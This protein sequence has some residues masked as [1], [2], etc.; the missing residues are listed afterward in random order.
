MTRRTL[1]LP[2]L[3]ALLAAACT[4][5]EI[6]HATPGTITVV[7]TTTQMQ[8]LVRNVGG[9][10]V[11]MVGILRPN[12][13]PHDYEPT[14]STA[15]SLAGAGLVVESGVGVDAW[16][17]DLVSAANPDTPVFVAADGLPVRTGSAG[18]PQ[19]DPHWWHDPTLFE[20]AATALGARLARLDPS[21]ARAYRANAARY[22]AAITAMDR[23]NMRL[24]ATVPRSQRKLVTNH[25]AFG[26]FAAHYGITVVGSV[27]PSL[28]TAAQPSARDVAD[29]VGRIRAQHVRA[30]FTESSLN[31]ALERQIAAEAGVRVEAD[32]YGDTLGPAGS[33]GATYLGMERWN[34]RAI[35]AGLLGRPAPQTSA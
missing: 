27:L 10:H 9:R 4:T 2:P 26:Y 30:I 29:L 5:T 21:H 20:R 22:V 15:I 12:V 13:D 3:L 11:R 24:I 14:P 28:S 1:L 7:A 31:P 23:A 6:P 16:A 18:E 34:M 35:V 17:D 33:P 25:D 19:G 8:D 32:L